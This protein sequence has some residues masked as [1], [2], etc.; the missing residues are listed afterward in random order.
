MGG[1]LDKPYNSSG[2]FLF[3]KSSNALTLLGERSIE[4]TLV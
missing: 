2:G 3:N 1:R 4:E